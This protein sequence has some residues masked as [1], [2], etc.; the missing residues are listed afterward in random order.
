MKDQPTLTFFQ[1]LEVSPSLVNGQDLKPSPSSKKKPS[2]KRFL[3]N[4]GPTC[5]S[6]ETSSDLTESHTPASICSQA[7]FLASHSAKPGSDEAR[8]MT[9]T[10]GLKCSAL[11]PKQSPVGCL[12]RT[13]LAS[14]DWGSTIVF[15]TWKASATKSRHRLKFQLVR[16][17]PDTS[18]TESGLWP[19]PN[20]AGGGNSCELTPSGNHYLRPSGQKAHLGLDQAVKMFPTPRANDAEKRGNFDKTNPRNGSTRERTAGN[21]TLHSAVKMWPTPSATETTGGGGAKEAA[22]AM[23][24]TPKASGCQRQLS[25]KDAV[26]LWPTPAAQDAKNSTLPVSQTHRD[27]IP[28]AMLRD[29]ESGQLNPQWVEWLMGYPIGHTALKDSATPSCRKSPTKSSKKSEI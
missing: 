3:N 4:I 2:S 24:G 28:G 27:S 25:L 18:E 9:A 23:A 13:L 14:T 1:E 6:S 26:K 19:T 5:Q 15:L 7:D 8:K 17:M 22:L 11:Y 10:S 16:S 20:V 12:V 29:G 21:Q